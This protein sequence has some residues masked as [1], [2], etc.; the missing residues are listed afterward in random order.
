[1]RVQALKKYAGGTR[2]RR[3]FLALPDRKETVGDLLGRDFR[4]EPFEID[5][6]LVAK[7]KRVD[8]KAVRVGKVEM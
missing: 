7:A 1:L 5:A 2:K 3:E 8:G 6:Q 4:T